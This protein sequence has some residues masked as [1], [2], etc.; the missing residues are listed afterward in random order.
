[1]SETARLELDGKTWELPLVTGSEGERAVDISRLRAES[2]LITLDSGYKNTGSCRSAITFL[3]GERGILRYRGYPIE[4]LAEQSSFLEVAYLLIRGELPTPD[5]LAGWRERI[6]YHTM[7]HEDLRRLYAAFPKDAHPMAVCAAV[8]A[9]LATFYPEDLDPTDSAQVNAS[10]ERLIA[11]FPTITSYSYKHSV[12]QPFLY[13]NNELGYV[14]NFLNMMFGTP[15]EEYHV[16]PVIAR[17]MDL[18]LILHADHEQ[19]CST[20]T[21]RMVG[22]SRANI[23]ASMSAGISALWG[24]RHG[25]AN[26]AV[27]QMLE[28]IERE[29]LS[30]REFVERAKKGNERLVGF[31]H[32]VYKSYDPRA[33]IIKQAAADVLERL[34]VQTRLLEIAVELERIALEDEYFIE[35]HLYPNVDFYSGVILKAIGIPIPVFTAIFAMGRMAGWIAQWLEYHAEPANAIYRPRQIYIGQNERHYVPLEKR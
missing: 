22:S 3:D 5:E 14:E 10:V 33:R 28:T 12:G 24:P 7:L 26:Q 15:C 23:F 19:N 32:R 20:S 6:R 25:G 31:G 35:R 1:M 4:E 9:A 17:A 34:G 27:I 16:D 13:P 18:L 8:V 21:V 2:G 30:G 11:K 29:G